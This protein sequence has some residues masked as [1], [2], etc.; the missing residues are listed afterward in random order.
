M[1]SV[2]P[3]MAGM[4]LIMEDV[5]S[6]LVPEISHSFPLRLSEDQE[7]MMGDLADRCVAAKGDSSSL[8]D[9]AYGRNA[10]TNEKVYLGDA[11][12]RDFHDPL[13]ASF[14]ELS[15]NQDA[16]LSTDSTMTALRYA[17]TSNPA[18][19][20]L[21]PN[22]AE[23]LLDGQLQKLN[24][25]NELAVGYTTSTRCSDFS[26]P[27]GKFTGMQGFVNQLLQLGTADRFLSTC[28]LNV[29]CN[30]SLETTQLQ[31]CN[32]GNAFVRLKAD[33]INDGDLFRCDV[34]ESE[35][36]SPCDPKDM[37]HRQGVWQN[38]CL[39]GAKA[40][41]KTMQVK[42]V[43][44][45]LQEFTTYVQEFD[46][47]IAAALQRLDDA[48]DQVATTIEQDLR[49]L[50]DR[51]LLTSIESIASESSCSYMPPLYREMLDSFCH[52]SIFGLISIGYAYVASG[53]MVGLSA[54]AMYTLWRSHFRGTQT[55]S[56][57]SNMP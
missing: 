10:V 8:F 35:N 33:I 29:T 1:L 36:G 55:N 43:P 30:S 11:F 2:T 48:K 57:A 23:M 22:R 41:S 37:V 18:D 51:H 39:L 26:G 3:P 56:I 47:R 54:F 5:D 21:V 32:A 20:F 31:A 40:G 53:I 17:I 19:A 16:A 52:Q 45:S 14:D 7:I 50:L 34:F 13:V 38:D 28:L 6:Q 46:S 25:D 44:C 12:V 49:D 4:C 27:G 24:M 42:K 15:Q 9:I